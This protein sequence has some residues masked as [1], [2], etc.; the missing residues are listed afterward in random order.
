MG[1]SRDVKSYDL[2]DDEDFN[3]E[4]RKKLD[5]AQNRRK[6]KRLKLKMRDE[7]HDLMTRE[8]DY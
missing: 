7:D 1:K 2:W 8:E 5:R 6:N 4:K 3:Y